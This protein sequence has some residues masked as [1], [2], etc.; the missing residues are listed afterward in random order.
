MTSQQ[1]PESGSTAPARVEGRPSTGSAGFAGDAGPR[2]LGD[3]ARAYLAKVRGG[4][5]GVLPALLGVVVLVAIFARADDLFLT[6]GNL[7]NLPAQ[8]AGFTLIAMGLVFVLLLG[9][10]DLSAGTAAGVCAGLMALAVTAGDGDL[11]T[12]LGSGTY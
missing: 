4:D 5:V 12:S 8:G 1:T 10:I 6:T 2:N 7:A 11:K 3:A 9:E